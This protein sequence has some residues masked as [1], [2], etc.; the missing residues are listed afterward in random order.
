VSVKTVTATEFLD[1]LLQHVPD[2]GFVGVRYYG[3]YANASKAL[4]KCAYSAGQLA[5]KGADEQTQ[6]GES[7]DLETFR[8]TQSSDFLVCSCCGIERQLVSSSMKG[9]VFKSFAQIN[10]S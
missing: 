10:D 9:V 1:S 2:K 3:I 7:S 5:P 6:T 4:E 8:A